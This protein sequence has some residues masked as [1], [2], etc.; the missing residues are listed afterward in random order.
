MTAGSM[1]KMCQLC[2]VIKFYGSSALHRAWVRVYDFA[3][4]LQV[5]DQRGP[6]TTPYSGI[7]TN[8]RREW[9]ISTCF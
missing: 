4:A 7:K 1:M 2:E 6:E 3:G 9:F 8:K 5:V